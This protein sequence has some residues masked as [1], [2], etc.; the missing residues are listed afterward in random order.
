MDHSPTHGH[1]QGPGGHE[2]RD[3]RTRV[4]VT[5]AVGLT[6]VVVAVQFLMLGVY[7]LMMRESAPERTPNTPVNI[8]RQLRTLRQDEARTLSSYGWVD[9][10]K[11]VV[12]I[13]ID[14]AIDLVAARGVPRGKGPRSV[15]ELNSHSGTPVEA[16]KPS[17][18]SERSPNPEPKPKDAK[19]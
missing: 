5:Y 13:P 14:R 19:P 4:I 2:T 15:A 8:Y 12:R 6:I 1:D 7:R 16:A 9:R 10:D 11:G 17:D 3:V 18:P